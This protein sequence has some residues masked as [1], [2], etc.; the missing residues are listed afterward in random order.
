M[1]TAMIHNPSIDCTCESGG[2]ALCEYRMLADVVIE[3]LNPIDGDEAE[4]A[5]CMDAVVRIA[6][7]VESLPCTC[8]PAMHTCGRCHALGQAR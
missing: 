4:V 8:V 1:S 3:K 7:Y 2:L 6:D 5:L